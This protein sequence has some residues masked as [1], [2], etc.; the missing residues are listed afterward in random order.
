MLR[1]RRVVWW[2]VSNILEDLT[3]RLSKIT[4]NL[5]LNESMMRTE[6]RASGLQSFSADFDR[7]AVWASSQNSGLWPVSTGATRAQCSVDDGPSWGLLKDSYAVTRCFVSS[8]LPTAIVCLMVINRLVFVME[9][10][11]VFCE[12]LI[13]YLHVKLQRLQHNGTAPAHPH[14]WDANETSPN[15]EMDDKARWGTAL[16]RATWVKRALSPALFPQFWSA[17]FLEVHPV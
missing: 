6:P 3:P 8:W 14:R 1:W 10:C 16:F 9:I 2:K 7:Q 17:T 13:D 4:I 11:C 15:S 12:V 5:R